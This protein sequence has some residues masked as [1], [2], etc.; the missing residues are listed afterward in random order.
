MGITLKKLGITRRNL[1]AD[2]ADCPDCED[3]QS[4]SERPSSGASSQ[5]PCRPRPREVVAADWT[6]SVQ[7]LTA[8]KQS[9]LRAALQRPRIYGIQR[10][11]A[12]VE[13][14]NWIKQ[15]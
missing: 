1:A 5:P 11:A 12:E 14:D 10:D 4:V 3:V 6:E 13:V 7:H 8:Q 2:C 15:I 9:R